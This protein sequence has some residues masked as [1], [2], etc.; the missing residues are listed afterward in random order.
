MFCL[1]KPEKGKLK[2][3]FVSIM[4]PKKFS[5]KDKS[6]DGALIKCTNRENIICVFV[7]LLTNRRMIVSRAVSLDV[8][9]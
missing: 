2:G 1:L 5:N 9:E 3:T 6:K 7:G 8:V 4:S